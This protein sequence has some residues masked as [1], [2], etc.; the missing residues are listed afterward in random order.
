MFGFIKRGRGG[1]MDDYHT[2]GRFSWFAVDESTAT[3]GK[4]T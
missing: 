2:R 3:H 1:L 4:G